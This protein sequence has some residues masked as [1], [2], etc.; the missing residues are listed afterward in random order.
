MNLNKNKR[1]HFIKG[2]ITD[3]ECINLIFDKYD[4]SGVI[5]FAAETHVDRSISD[6]SEFI[7]S[8]IYGTFTLLECIRQCLTNNELDDDFKFI[9]VSTDEVYGSIDHQKFVE[10]TPLHPNNPYSA[11]KASADLFVLSYYNTYKFP[12][13]ISRCSNNFGPRQHVEK[14]IPT[15][16]TKAISHDSIPIYGDGQQVRDWI[17]VDNH[18]SAIDCILQ[19][20]RV[21]EIYNIGEDNERKN[22][23]IA[24][25]ILQQLRIV[26]GDDKITTNLIKYVQDRPGHD[27]RY[28]IDAT[29]IR[30]E[31]EWAPDVAFED[32]LKLTIDWYINRSFRAFGISITSI[33]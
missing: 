6:A 8:N 14:F 28:A 33:D 21:G 31:L 26:C 12:G 23:D 16:I 17:F 20:G 13:I 1:F 18:C 7:K 4:V 5:N 22:I 24:T 27:K 11:S 15:I 3:A 29:K 30:E 9:Q 10:T 19:N 32:G 2:D 25:S